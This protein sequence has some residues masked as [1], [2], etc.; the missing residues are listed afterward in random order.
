MREGV[1]I[2]NRLR[3][4]GHIGW[5]PEKQLLFGELFQTRPFHGAKQR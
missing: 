1:C 2:R 3:W 5:M 4:L